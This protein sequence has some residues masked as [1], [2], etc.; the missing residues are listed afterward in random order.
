MKRLREPDGSPSDPS[1]LVGPPS[2]GAKRAEIQKI[3]DDLECRLVAL[4]KEGRLRQDEFLNAPITGSPAFTDFQDRIGDVA[5]RLIRCDIE[6]EI[7]DN[8][9]KPGP[10]P[11]PAEEHNK[12]YRPLRG[13][14][15]RACGGDMKRARGEF[16]RR[17]S[18]KPYFS[19]PKTAKNVW[20]MLGRANREK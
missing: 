4:K 18:R 17:A 1:G 19:S 20:S 10:D 5:K 7:L 16:I 15:I 8:L 13:E 9:P 6:L 14:C 11:A 2:R 12:K 3:R